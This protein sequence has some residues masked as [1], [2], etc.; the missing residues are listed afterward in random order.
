[1][2]KHTLTYFGMGGR[3]EPIRLAAVIGRFPFTNKAVAYKDF[4]EM[5]AG[6]PLGQ[7]PILEI[8]EGGTKTVIPQSDAILRYFG[9][10]T[11]LYPDDPVEAMQVDSLLDT[12]KDLE[13][14]LDVTFMGPVRFLFADKEWEEEDKLAMRKRIL[15]KAIPKYLGF[16][17]GKLRDN[18]TGWL[19]GKNV[20]IADLR[21][22]YPCQLMIGKGIL[23]G[24]PAE[25]LDAY[26]NIK[27]CM[28]GIEKIPQVAA[29]YE[30]Y[31]GGKY[32]NFDF[33]PK[34]EE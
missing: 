25:S 22:Y 24:I 31:P 21:L 23:D 34:D 6:L 13:M 2:A 32:G 33:V 30:K 20:T 27:T 11:G 8:E 7:L 17:E 14:P 16:V 10:Q 28:T 3:A 15:E 29:W 5:V 18:G 1:M 19:V 12:I 4:G 26:P 9:K